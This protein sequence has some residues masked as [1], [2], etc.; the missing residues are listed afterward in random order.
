MALGATHPR[1]KPACHSPPEYNELMRDICTFKMLAMS[2]DVYKT[3]INLLNC[4][5]YSSMFCVSVS[6]A[7]G[8]TIIVSCCTWLACTNFMYTSFKQ[9]SDKILTVLGSCLIK[10]YETAQRDINFYFRS[11]GS[12]ARLE[13]KLWCN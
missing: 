10:I 2:W 11:T 3:A 13:Y 6:P 8:M 1:K 7:A 4:G 5:C 9:N 12:P